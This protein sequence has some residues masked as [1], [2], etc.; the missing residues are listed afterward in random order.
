MTDQ[1]QSPHDGEEPTVTESPQGMD[2]YRV[3]CTSP[4]LALH[5]VSEHADP[6]AIDRPPIENEGQHHYEHTGPGTIR[7]HARDDFSYNLAK[8]RAV[9]REA[10]A[11]GKMYFALWTDRYGQK[12]WQG[13]FPSDETAGESVPDGAR[14][15][16]IACGQDVDDG[17]EVQDYATTGKDALRRMDETLFLGSSAIGDRIGITE[18]LPRRIRPDRSAVGKYS[19]DLMREIIQAMNSESTVIIVDMKDPAQAEEEGFSFP[20]G[21]RLALHLAS[22][23]E[24]EEAWRRTGAQNEAAHQGIPPFLHRHTSV[25]HRYE[26]ALAEKIEADTGDGTLEDWRPCPHPPHEV[27]DLA[28]MI[29]NMHQQ[30]PDMD[31]AM[32]AVDLAWI[33]MGGWPWRRRLKAAA[34]LAFS[35]SRAPSWG[36]GW[37]F[38]KIADE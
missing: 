11:A 18:D 24:D 32:L 14:F 13:P 33:K 27:M 9:L 20:D 5:L 38:R 17:P 1:A 31:P 26:R 16:A 21:A 30:A 2:R 10:A 35:G 34:L 7:H 12:G 4:T 29:G 19:L 36:F 25:Q 28:R 15:S 3:P 6:M 23:H 8:V 22:A 37:R